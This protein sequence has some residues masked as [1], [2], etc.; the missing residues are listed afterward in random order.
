[1]KRLGQPV[2]VDS[3]AADSAVGHRVGKVRKGA[4]LSDY[5]WQKESNIGPPSL[6]RESPIPKPTDCITDYRVLGKA[7]GKLKSP[8]EVIDHVIAGGS[9]RRTPYWDGRQ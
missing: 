9:L 2:P 7:A 8:V 4:R 1:M 3:K 6:R 5:G